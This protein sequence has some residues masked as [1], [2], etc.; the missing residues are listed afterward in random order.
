MWDVEYVVGGI[1]RGM[2]KGGMGP[3]SGVLGWGCR[4]FSRE[5]WAL[6]FTAQADRVAATVQRL[7]HEANEQVKRG[8]GDGRGWERGRRSERMRLEWALA[9]CQARATGGESAFSLQA[10]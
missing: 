3:G 2:V 1:W 5:Q 8:K 6:S 9:G 4:G 7:S 10:V